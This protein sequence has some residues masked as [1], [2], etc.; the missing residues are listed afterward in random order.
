LIKF[1]A[2]TT[3]NTYEQIGAVKGLSGNLFKM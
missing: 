2:Q 3:T 1:T